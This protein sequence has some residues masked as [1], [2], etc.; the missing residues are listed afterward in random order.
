M[1]QGN[2]VFSHNSRYLSFQMMSNT[3]QTP[4]N[5]AYNADS[6]WE[7][8]HLYFPLMVNLSDVPKMK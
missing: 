4:F 1:P 7:A 3:T 2:M 6:F 8:D 5:I